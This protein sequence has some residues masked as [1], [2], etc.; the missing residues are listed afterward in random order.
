[1]SQQ[2]CIFCFA[3]WINAEKN[4][5]DTC[6]V[7]HFIS[8]PYATHTN[9][10]VFGLTR[11]ELKHTI[12]HTQGEHGDHYTA[13]VVQF[14]EGIRKDVVWYMG[15]HLFKLKL[16]N[17]DCV[18]DSSI[19][20]GRFVRLVNIFYYFSHYCVVKNRWL[21]NMTLYEMTLDDSICTA[22][23]RHKQNSWFC[24]EIR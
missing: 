9:I 19:Y 11:Q 16:R 18:N 1:M 7:S 4:I 5:L 17:L 20:Y 23:N 21:T 10:I 15:I 12:F 14:T 22:G 24:K 8:P 2:R 3:F 13:D 6:I